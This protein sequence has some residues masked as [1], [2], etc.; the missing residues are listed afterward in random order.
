MYSVHVSKAPR[1]HVD[2]EEACVW[3][4]ANKSAGHD[5]VYVNICKDAL[6]HSIDDD[7]GN[8]CHHGLHVVVE[9]DML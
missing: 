8:K 1:V 6:V 7:P 3:P 2:D 5:V 9:A 4:L